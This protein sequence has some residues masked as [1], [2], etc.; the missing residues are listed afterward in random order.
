MQNLQLFVVL[1][2]GYNP[3]DLIESHN[4]F[5]GVG[6][7][8][9]SL[10]PEMKKSWPY[11]THVDGYMILKHVDGFDIQIKAGEPAGTEFPNLIMANIG[12]YKKGKFAEFHNLIPFVLTGKNDSILEKMKRDP[13][14]LE[15]QSLA[16]S[17][18]SHI[19]D[20]HSITSFDVDDVINVQKI[21]KGYVVGLVPSVTKTENILEMGYCHTELR[22]M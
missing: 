4:L 2:G 6:T 9:Q 14:F 22:K 17:T 12:F 1:L 19:D 15:G 13:D 10:L 3:G 18:R 21:I 7:D 11:T 8:V 16:E 5:I 20:K